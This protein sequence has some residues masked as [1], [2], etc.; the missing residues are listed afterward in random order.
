MQLRRL[1]SIVA[2]FALAI[3][4]TWAGSALAVGPEDD[5]AF[6][7]GIGAGFGFENF[8][9][10]GGLDIDTAFGFDAWGGYKFNKWIATELQLEYLN[11][12]DAKI[13]GIDIDGQAVTFGAN[14]KLFPLASVL[15]DRVQPFV[16]AGPGF[17]W[18]ELDAGGFDADELDFSAR[19]GGGIDFYLTDNI[20]LQASSSYVLSTGDLDG[21]DYIS[22]VAGLQY[23]F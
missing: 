16:M 5:S 10:T 22:L 14:L 12:F 1:S 11:G 15:P 4:I 6:Y 19:F 7:V 8:D 18:L 17:T 21:T 2:S 3:G 23:K 13:L 20:A 9:G